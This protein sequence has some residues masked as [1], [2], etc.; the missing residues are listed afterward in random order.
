MR[1]ADRVSREIPAELRD[2]RRAARRLAGRVQR[3]PVLR[4]ATLDAR[5]GVPVYLKCEQFQTGGAFKLRGALNAVLSLSPAERAAGVATHSSG[6]HGQALARAARL[7]GIPA[8]I[9]MPHN[10]VRAKR[11][12]VEAQGA[13]IIDCEPGMAGREAVLEHVV[14]DTGAHIVHPYN[15]WRVIAGQGT[16]SLE[17]LQAAPGVTALLTPVGGGGLLAGACLAAQSRRGI[18]VFGAEPVEADD[19]ARAFVSG[20]I[21]ALANPATIAD[22]LRATLGWRPFQI[23]RAHA[24]A[25]LTVD[26]AEILAAMRFV[27]HELKLVIE[28]SAAVP[29][30]LLLSRR[31]ALAGPV[32]V[33]VSGGN[34]DLDQLPWS[35]TD[36]R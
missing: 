36:A 32:G 8:R 15:D 25:I 7:L 2:I 31:L 20:R 33:I 30:A 3:T 35:S 5:V 18:R 27:W 11:Q 4:S 12:A 6:N 13:Q 10:A 23:I 9:V 14:R 1:P 17:L 29:I 34:V 22:G 21:E 28:P 16:A 26:E 24:E 19:A